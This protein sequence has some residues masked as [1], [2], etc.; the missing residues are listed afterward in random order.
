VA[1][2]E[3]TLINELVRRMNETS[4]RVKTL[5]NRINRVE[6]DFSLLSDDTSRKIG[7]FRADLE[8]LSK[9]ISKIIE[10]ITKINVELKKIK[11]DL[12]NAATKTEMKEFEKFIEIISPVTS[13]FVTKDEV[14]KIVEE[15]I[16]K[17]I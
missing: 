8:N 13:Q 2:E 10:D 5:E 11:G 15:K 12:E 16:R 6:K 9:Q 7:E 3:K 17:K 1:P 14:E 4:I